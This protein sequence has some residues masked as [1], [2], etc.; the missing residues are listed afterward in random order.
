MLPTCE[1]A[2]YP[3]FVRT[4]QELFQSHAPRWHGL[5]RIDLTEEPGSNSCRSLFS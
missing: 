5:L 2:T 3:E 4:V 1:T